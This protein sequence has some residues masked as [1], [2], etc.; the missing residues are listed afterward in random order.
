MLTSGLLHNYTGGSFLAD[1]NALDL[2]PQFGERSFHSILFV[3]NTLALLV[4]G[5]I[6]SVSLHQEMF[7]LLPVSIDRWL[8]DS[9]CST[10]NLQA[11]T[12]QSALST[13]EVPQY[14]TSGY[15]R[16]HLSV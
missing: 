1:L 14:S 16:Y 8:I 4:D 6:P 2:L 9:V 13:L 15:P 11:M 7:S 3:E 12:A 10:Y 5:F